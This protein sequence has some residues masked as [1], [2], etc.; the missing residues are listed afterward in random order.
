MTEIRKY[1]ATAKIV[2]P[3]AVKA[4]CASEGGIA[5]EGA[6]YCEIPEMGFLDPDLIYC[7]YGL[8]I[9][10]L[11]IQANQKVLVEPTIDDDKR[12]F[13]TGIADCGGLTPAD[14]DQMIL[15]F[16]SQVIYASTAGTI[17]LSSKTA[18]EPFA[19]G[20]KLLTWITTY[21]NTQFNLHTHICASS[22][23][24]SAPPVPTATPPTDI[25]STKI[26]GE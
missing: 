1:V 25:L 5:H 16:L 26:M 22:G 10:Y 18:S 11:K 24:P 12:F 7:R 8:S 20:N 15:Q 2:N 21:I 9:P 19:L 13:Y 4:R 23:S 3:T 6:I 14:T 17:H